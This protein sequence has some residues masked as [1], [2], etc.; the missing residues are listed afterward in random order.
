MVLRDYSS[1]WA[2]ITRGRVQGTI[3]ECQDQTWIGH[4]QGKHLQYIIFLTPLLDFLN[5]L[6]SYQFCSDFTVSLFTNLVTNENIY[7][8]IYVQ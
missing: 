4:V 7:C 3:K 1:V 6:N 8:S 2:Q 5:N